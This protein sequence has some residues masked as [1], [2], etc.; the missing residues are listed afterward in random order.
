VTVLVVPDPTTLSPRYNRTVGT[1][2]ALGLFT[3]VVGRPPQF[4]HDAWV[5]TA[6]QSP[7]PRLTIAGV[8]FSR[9][10][11]GSAK[12][13][14]SLLAVPACVMAAARRT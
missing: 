6:V 4:D 13:R 11:S 7:A 10:T 2:A 12:G 9:C 5:W 8:A 3:L 1:A 14:G